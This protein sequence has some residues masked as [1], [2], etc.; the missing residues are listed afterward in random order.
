MLLA[1]GA[2][3]GCRKKVDDPANTDRPVP[4]TGYPAPR[5]PSYFKPPSSIDDLMP[6]ARSLVRNK[7]GFLGMGMGVLQAGE[8]VLIVPN[9]SSDPTVVQ[10]IVK[11]LAERQVQA[12]VKYTYELLGQTREQAHR[13]EAQE[14][15]G[16]RI[17]EAGIYQASTWIT[18]QFPDPGPP[19]KWLKERR[20]DV[21]AELFPGDSGGPAQAPATG[22]DGGP[23]SF[24][25]EMAL[26]GQAIQDYMKKNP[27]TRGA[28]WGTAGGT[29]LRR[30]MYPMQEKFLGTFTTDNLWTLQSQMTNYPGDVWQLAEEQ[31]LEP[32]VHVDRVEITDPEGT[33][34][35]A[36]LTQ[37]MAE[38]WSEGAY[39][40][41]HLYMFPN[42]ATGRFGYSLGV[43]AVPG[44][45]RA[46]LPVP[47]QAGVLVPL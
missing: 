24:A 40:R 42:Q 11:A 9:L 37:D 36:D 31:M 7:S 4:Q 33:N 29:G 32:L 45:E 47:H 18:G 21:Y 26:V 14:Q 8:T 30:A 2:A 38:R 5:W 43:P 19:K 15:K 34:L 16:R 13:L 25:R 20:P 28:F 23:L 3:G 6:A 27:G 39:Q 35:W 17:A 10:A 44:A 41:G 46:C 1:I 22:E 12:Q